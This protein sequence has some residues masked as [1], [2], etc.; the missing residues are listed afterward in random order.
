MEK[1]VIFQ[2]WI[3]VI[4]DTKWFIIVAAGIHM[5]IFEFFSL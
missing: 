4:S 3:P 5:N 1:D 2:K